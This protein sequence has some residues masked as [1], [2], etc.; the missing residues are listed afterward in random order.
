MKIQQLA[1]L[2]F[3]TVSNVYAQ[4]PMPSSTL[5]SHQFI[6]G[7]NF[8]INNIKPYDQLISSQNPATLVL[9]IDGIAI[10][11][12]S[13]VSYEQNFLQVFYHPSIKE[14]E[15]IYH[16]AKDIDG[17]NQYTGWNKSYFQRRLYVA[18]TGDKKKPF[19]YPGSSIKELAHK[20]ASKNTTTKHIYCDV[21]HNFL[22]DEIVVELS[23][24]NKHNRFASMPGYYNGAQFC[25]YKIDDFTD[26]S[27]EVIC[28]D[29]KDGFFDKDFTME[30]IQQND[31]CLLEVFTS[32]LVEKSTSI[33]MTD[34]TNPK[35]FTVEIKP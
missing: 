10:E 5:V 11:T 19:E 16:Y 15:I 23:A 9:S 24:V 20:N 34:T 7:H 25:V 26:E 28:R 2:L 21:D 6:Q 22:S 31:S 13:H 8:R 30:I 29:N 3:L 1:V 33:Y 27:T 17:Y 35:Y 14:F 12:F 4:G 18:L 32:I